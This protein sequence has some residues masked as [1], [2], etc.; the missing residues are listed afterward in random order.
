[1]VSPDPWLRA[2]RRRFLDALAGTEHDLL[3]VEPVHRRDQHFEVFLADAD[4]QLDIH[5]RVTHDRVDHPA[6]QTLIS[7][8][9]RGRSEAAP[10]NRFGLLPAAAPRSA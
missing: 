9:V 8:V 7:R 2:A 6:H 10:R 4:R 5:A 3:P 1:M